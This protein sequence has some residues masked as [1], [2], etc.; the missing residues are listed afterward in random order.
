MIVVCGGGCKP[1]LY[2]SLRVTGDTL[3]RPPF[4]V[5]VFEFI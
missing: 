5:H 2:L 1:L 4:D 3:S